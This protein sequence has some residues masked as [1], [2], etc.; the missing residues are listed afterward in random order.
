MLLF[1]DESGHDRGE[2][3]YE[4]LAGV[5]IREQDLWSLVQDIRNSEAEYFGMHLAEVG[6]EFKGRALLKSK[7]FRFAGQAP[8]IPPVE[9][10]VHVQHFLQKGWREASGAPVETR[11]RQEF[12]A[13]GQAVLAFIE[14]VFRLMTKYR[15]KVFA[16]MVD[17]KA[18]RPADPGFLRKDYAFFLER[19][20]YYLEDT[21]PNEMGLLVFDEREKAQCRILLDQMTKYFLETRK[22]YT[23]S[24]RIV[25]EPFFVHSDL[26][27]AVQLADIAAYC[28]NWGIRLNNMVEPVRSE[29]EHLA[30]AAF[31]LRYVGHRTDE[32]S[33]QEWTQ[34]GVFYLSDLRPKHEQEELIE[35]ER[36]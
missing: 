21:S 25:P 27:T 36:V 30:H 28:L 4:V 14:R 10:T 34:Y 18:P 23:R 15:V 33:G 9:R 20:F 11:S 7:V 5:A 32:L 13:Y 8:A 24:S 31:D 12:T 35:G 1:I 29:I 3:P 22:G 19:F 2:A 16:A 6:V 26:T 17:K